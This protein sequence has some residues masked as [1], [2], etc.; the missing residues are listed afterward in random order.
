MKQDNDDGI[1]WD[2][3]TPLALKAP[4]VA[5]PLAWMVSEPTCT[6]EAKSS[7]SRSS[8]ALLAMVRD[9]AL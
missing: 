9:V 3:M 8:T 5:R 2:D 7:A 6:R 1:G 4:R